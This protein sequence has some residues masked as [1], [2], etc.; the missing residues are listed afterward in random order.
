MSDAYAL[1][2]GVQALLTSEA[3]FVAAITALLGAAV[4]NVVIGNVPVAS[5]PA[6]SIPCFVV[7]QGDGKP[8]ATADS[9]EFQTIGL[10]M[11]SFASELYVSLVWNDQDPVHAAVTRAKLPTLF[12]Q[13]FMRNPQPGGVD[14]AGLAEWVPDRGVNHPLQ[15][16][17]ATISGNY[18]ITKT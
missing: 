7:E 9:I 12:A 10:A 2:S 8:V 6:A 16:W 13:L 17:R 18:T 4:S 1:S 5:I 14:F 11:T 3:T 15:I